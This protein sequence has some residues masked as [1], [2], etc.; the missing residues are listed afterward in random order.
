MLDAGI[1]SK[2]SGTV[3]AFSPD[4]HSAFGYLISSN[5]SYMPLIPIFSTAFAEDLR[6]FCDF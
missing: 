1:E 4:L 5:P 3:T 2:S 6:F